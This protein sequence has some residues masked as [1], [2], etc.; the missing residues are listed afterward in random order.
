MPQSLLTVQFYRKA[1]IKG[2]VSLQLIRPWLEDTA[3]HKVN[4]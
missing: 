1:D 2:L 3:V 4:K